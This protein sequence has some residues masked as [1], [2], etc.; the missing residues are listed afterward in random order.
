MKHRPPLL[1]N[2]RSGH[3]KCQPGT[4]RAELE[5]KISYPP[6]FGFIICVKLDF[7]WEGLLEGG[8]LKDSCKWTLVA[9]S[10]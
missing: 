2:V 3:E 1:G 5:N 9:T 8:F 6:G 7:C 10:N 4:N